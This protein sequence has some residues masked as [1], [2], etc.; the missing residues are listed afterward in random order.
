[1]ITMNRDIY[2]GTY[3]YYIII[4]NNKLLQILCLFFYSLPAVAT[5]IQNKQITPH[6][7]VLLTPLKS[8]LSVLS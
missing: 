6:K 8:I 4:K 3:A 1:M 5:I 2:I 7:M